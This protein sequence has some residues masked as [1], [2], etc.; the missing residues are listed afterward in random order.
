LAT[1]FTS[2]VVGANGA[3]KIDWPAVPQ[4][5]SYNIYGRTP[6]NLGRIGTVPAGTLTFTDTGAVTPVTG[7]PLINGA[8]HRYPK[9]GTLT[10]ETQYTN[11]NFYNL[12]SLR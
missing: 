9:L 1:N 5:T 3:V 10:V 7:L 6:L 12:G 11:R 4:A 8:G 2:V